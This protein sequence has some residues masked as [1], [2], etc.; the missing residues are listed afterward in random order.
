MRNLWVNYT[1]KRV[2]GKLTLNFP[3]SHFVGIIFTSLCKIFT[4][5]SFLRSGK[6]ILLSSEKLVLK[7]QESED[8]ASEVN[9]IT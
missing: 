5:V 9:Q 3:R 6:F 8:F 1:Y 4:L 7:S 2:N